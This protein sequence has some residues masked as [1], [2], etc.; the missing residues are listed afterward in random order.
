MSAAQ[1]FQYSNTEKIALSGSL[2][3]GK[4]SIGSDQQVW[5]V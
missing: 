5:L 4:S 2:Q 3:S 1:Q